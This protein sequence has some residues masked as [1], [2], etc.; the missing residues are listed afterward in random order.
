MTHSV[1]CTC[2]ACT[3][4]IEIVPQTP[5]VIDLTQEPTYVAP[6]PNITNIASVGP[7]GPKG[8]KGDKGDPGFS[9]TVA[10]TWTQSMPDNPW[11]INH[12]L[13]FMPNV[14]VQDSAGTI[15]EGEIRY[16]DT[17]NLTLTFSS[18]FSGHAYLS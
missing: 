18:A 17:N 10:Y 5:V 7:Q 4:V 11:I 6:G 8:E 13:G 14:T 3:Q 2:T 12:N 16:T 9:P 1:D 15:V